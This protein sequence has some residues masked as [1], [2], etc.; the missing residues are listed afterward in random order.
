[1]GEKYQFQETLVMTGANLTHL[2]VAILVSDDF[3]QAELEEPRKAL[4]EAGA[5]TSVVAPKA[6]SVQAMKHDDK[7][8]KVPVDITL[9]AAKPEDFDALLLPGGALNADF[10][11][12]EPK[13]Q[14]F[15]RSFDRSKKPIALI[16]HAPWVMISAG[17]LKG[18]TVSGYHTIQDD[19]RNAGGKWK[20]EEV[21]RDSN[22][23]S[24]RQPS[25]IPAFNR[26]MI[27]LFS[28]KPRKAKSA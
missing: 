20:D 28:E 19:I 10:L 6:G 17:L 4:D 25:D 5:K 2:R 9:D 12:M 23:V 14:E 13:A 22:W 7:T 11:R 1:V 16:C 3:E 24:S 27:S 18:R 21:V 15:V 26:E 8:H